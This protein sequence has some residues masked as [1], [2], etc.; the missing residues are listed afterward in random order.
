VKVPL[1]QYI[2]HFGDKGLQAIASTGTDNILETKT[3]ENS[4]KNKTKHK[5]TVSKKN[6]QNTHKIP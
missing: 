2:G 6:I 4:P 1:T 5:L 3:R